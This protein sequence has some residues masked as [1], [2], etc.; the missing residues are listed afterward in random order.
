MSLVCSEKIFKVFFFHVDLNCDISFLSLHKNCIN[1]ETSLS[2]FNVSTEF[3][4]PFKLLK[5]FEHF[6]AVIY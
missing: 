3:F 4:F 6:C 2:P 1:Y 5:L